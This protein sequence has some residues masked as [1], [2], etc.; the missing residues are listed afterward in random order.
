MKKAEFP[1]V[2]RIGQTK[3]TIYKTSSHGCDSFTVVWFEGAIAKTNSRR[4]IPIQPNL[5][6]W[7]KLYSKPKGKVVEIVGVS[8]AIYRM[9]DDTR[10][11][12]PKNPKSKLKPVI[13]WRR[14]A[15]RHSFCSYRLAQIKTRLTDTLKVG[16]IWL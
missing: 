9:I 14:N 11:I 3:A 6:A 16:R 1:K 4:L 7:L 5:K 10:P 2:V 12:D 15:L 8:S 13:E